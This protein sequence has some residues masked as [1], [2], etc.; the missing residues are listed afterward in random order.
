M[1]VLSESSWV[2]A[3]SL[4]CSA[5][6][7]PGEDQQSWPI[8]CDAVQNLVALAAV[9]VLLSATQQSLQWHS[10]ELIGYNDEP[11]G[12]RVNAGMHTNI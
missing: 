7:L 5:L 9:W 12:F 10:V 11:R 8:A 1:S 6:Q 4:G 2:W 3:G